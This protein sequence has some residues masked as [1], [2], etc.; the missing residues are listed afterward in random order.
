MEEGSVEG[1]INHLRALWLA[2]PSDK[3]MLNPMNQLRSIVKFF[4]DFSDLTAVY[5]NA[6]AAPTSLVWGSIRLILT[7]CDVKCT[8]ET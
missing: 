5:F 8:P 1:L 2:K 3:K 7:V 4:S 6:D